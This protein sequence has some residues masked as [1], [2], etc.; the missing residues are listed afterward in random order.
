MSYKMIDGKLYE[1]K[2][3][4]TNQLKIEVEQCLKVVNEQNSIINANENQ[5]ASIESRCDSQVANIEKQIE[6]LKSN[7]E[8]TKERCAK[9]CVPYRVNVRNAEDR[10]EEI[11]SRL[12]EKKEAIQELLP[13]AA[14]KLGF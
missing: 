13:E 2:E 8:A 10:I 4:D 9:D 5:I 7:I 11:K 6:A 3:V 12:E 14:N 1:V